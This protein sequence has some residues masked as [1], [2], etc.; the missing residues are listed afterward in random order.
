[1]GEYPKNN[2]VLIGKSLLESMKNKEFITIAN[3]KFK[4]S[5]TFEGDIGFENGGIVLNIEDAGAIFNTI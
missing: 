1:M 3:K 2:E 4:V 5:G